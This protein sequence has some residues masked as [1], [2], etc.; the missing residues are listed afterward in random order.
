METF[1]RAGKHRS[2]GS[3]VVIGAGPVGLFV[4][5]QLKTR[6]PQMHVLCLE[7]YTEYQRKH[8]LNIEAASFKATQNSSG[9]FCVLCEPP[10]QP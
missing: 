10:L 6:C 9:F 5:L 1:Q 4:A 7:K 8:V 2:R 3:T